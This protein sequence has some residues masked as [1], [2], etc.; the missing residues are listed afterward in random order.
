[1]AGDTKLNRILRKVMLALKEKGRG[2]SCLF[3]LASEI[4]EKYEK[5]L[6]C[7]SA[8]LREKLLPRLLPLYR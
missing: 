6:L 7:A 8:P 2:I 5:N 4:N 3:F 1:M